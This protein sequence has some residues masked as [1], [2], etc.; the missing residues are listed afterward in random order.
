M[1]GV[2]SSNS[3]MKGSNGTRCYG[4][5]LSLVRSVVNMIVE[6]VG[7]I[8]GQAKVKKSIDRYYFTYKG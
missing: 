2:T 4:G 5:I 7:S 1:M 6:R 3:L 8:K